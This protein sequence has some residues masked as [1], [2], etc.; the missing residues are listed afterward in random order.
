MPQTLP[1]MPLRPFFALLLL[2]L[3]A[4]VG[5][6]APV[7]ANSHISAVTVYADRAV[8]TRTV[9]LDPAAT[10]VI[11]VAFEKLPTS[12]LDQSLQ[13][14]GRGT[15]QTS[16][17]DVAARATFVDFTPNARIKALEDELR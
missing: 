3:A 16:I 5:R 13:V 9:A 1:P 8:V 7:I 15:A 6:A 11:E 10:G 4:A 12:L 14:S 2:S 17:L